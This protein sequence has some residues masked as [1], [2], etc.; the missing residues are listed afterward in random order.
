MLSPDTFVSLLQKLNAG[1]NVLLNPSSLAHFFVFLLFSALSSESKALNENASRPL[2]NTNLRQ[3]VDLLDVVSAYISSSH[4][5]TPSDLNAAK[6]DL[7]QQ[8]LLLRVSFVAQKEEK[9]EE[10]DSAPSRSYAVA[11]AAKKAWERVSASAK[12]LLSKSNLANQFLS[13]TCQQLVQK[14]IAPTASGAH[15]SMDVFVETVRDLDEFAVSLRGSSA[16]GRRLV[17]DHLAVPRAEWLRIRNRVTMKP[18]F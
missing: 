12:E 15:F 5:T 6:I 17:L 4:F 10:G 1:K 8:V 11:L 2:N 7:L 14:L 3:V 16:E 9:E 18:F 13:T